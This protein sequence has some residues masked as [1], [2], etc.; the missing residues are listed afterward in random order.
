MTMNDD[1]QGLVYAVKQRDAEE[2]VAINTPADVRV[3]LALADQYEQ[4]DIRLAVRFRILEGD[5]AFAT[6]F[7]ELVAELEQSGF[8][9]KISSGQQQDG[10]ALEDGNAH[11]YHDRPEG[12]TSMV[13]YPGVRSHEGDSDTA[14]PAV[15]TGVVP[16]AR[17]ARKV[18]MH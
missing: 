6:E 16:P 5:S 11:R 12:W 18:P 4:Q 9:F 8:A 2:W 1:E 17:G 10:K 3:K 15:E 13:P 7:P 14:L